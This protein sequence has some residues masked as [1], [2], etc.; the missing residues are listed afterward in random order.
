MGQLLASVDN[1]TLN[2]EKARLVDYR[3]EGFAFLGFSV[4]RRHSRKGGYYPHVEPSA[5]SCGNLRAKVRKLWEVRARNPPTDEVV[6]HLNQ[7]TQGWARAFHYA[8]S[9]AKFGDLQRYVRQTLRRWLWHKHGRTRAQYE[10]YTNDRLHE[11]YGLW[12]SP[13]HAAWNKT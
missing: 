9:T 13:L 2:E 5:K 8:N 3:Q 6:T 11:H 7:V 4:S 10:H 1:L 12:S